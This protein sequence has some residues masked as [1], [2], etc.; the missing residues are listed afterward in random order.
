VDLIQSGKIS[1]K[2]HVTHVFPLDKINEAF[3]VA[4]DFHESIEVMIEP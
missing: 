4:M 1:A 2:K 3:E